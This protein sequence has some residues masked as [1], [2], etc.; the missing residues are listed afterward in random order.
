MNLVLPEKLPPPCVHLF[1]H[2]TLYNL[3]LHP[4]SLVARLQFFIAQLALSLY[5]SILDVLLG[6][7]LLNAVLGVRAIE[8]A[9][10]GIRRSYVKQS[11]IAYQIWVSLLASAILLVLLQNFVTT[12]AYTTF[13]SSILNICV[14]ILNTLQV[15][16]SYKV[17][18]KFWIAFEFMRAIELLIAVGTGAVNLAPDHSASSNQQFSMPDEEPSYLKYNSLEKSR[19]QLL[20]YTES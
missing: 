17:M 15:R 14:E 11:L 4:V 19:I 3:C 8:S 10:K 6:T 16:A 20:S 18:T 12:I 1:S 7:L 2:Q 9:T 5:G 13:I